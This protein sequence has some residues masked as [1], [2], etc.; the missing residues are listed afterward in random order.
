MKENWNQLICLLNR[1]LILYLGIG[2]GAVLFVMV[3]EPFSVDLLDFEGRVL[4]ASGFGIIIFLVIFLTGIAYPSFV[5]DYSQDEKYPE[6]Q[7]G[8]RNFLV[9]FLS[10]LSV[11]LYMTLFRSINFSPY[12]IYKTALICL[13]PPVITGIHDKLL[14]LREK[15]EALLM[16]EEILLKKIE[17]YERDESNETIELYSENKSE[18]LSLISSD[19]LFIKSADNYAEIHYTD[20]DQIKKRLIRNT[21]KNIE[22]QIQEFPNFIRCHRISIVNVHKIERL[23]GNCNTHALIIKGIDEQLPVSR[24]CFLKVKEAL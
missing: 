7:H 8:K 3:F 9:W 14:K 4:F 6:L 11:T 24:S 15:N 5:R 13:L 18:K 1:K 21:L 20:G 2:L 10:F 16:S 12:D 17:T 23:V 22:I 19:V